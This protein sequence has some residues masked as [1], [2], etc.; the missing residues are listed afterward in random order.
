MWN[1]GSRWSRS[2]RM[3]AH[4]SVVAACTSTVTTEGIMGETPDGH[5]G[6]LRAAANDRP[7]DPAA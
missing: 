3:R 7:H 5:R 2:S 4:R 6:G 1:S